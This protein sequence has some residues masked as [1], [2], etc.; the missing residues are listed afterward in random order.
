MSEEQGFRREWPLNSN[1]NTDQ[2]AGLIKKYLHALSLNIPPTTCKEALVENIELSSIY[3]PV[4]AYNVEG[5]PHVLFMTGEYDKD[6]ARLLY[7]ISKY[8]AETMPIAKTV[9]LTVPSPGP[10]VQWISEPTKAAA[11][12]SS[13]YSVGLKHSMEPDAL[14]DSFKSAL[15][16]LFGV[17]LPRMGEGVAMLDEVLAKELM[18]VWDLAEKGR[19]L[20]RPTAR[21]IN[22]I[23]RV[24][25]DEALPTSS[26]F[27]DQPLMNERVRV[28]KKDQLWYRFQSLEYVENMFFKRKAGL[29]EAYQGLFSLNQNPEAKVDRVKLK[30]LTATVDKNNPK[31]SPFNAGGV[32]GSSLKGEFIFARKTLLEQY[33]PVVPDLVWAVA[34]CSVCRT[35][36]KFRK[37]F[38]P[39]SLYRVGQSMER[40]KL[41]L[42]EKTGRATFHC[43][44]CGQ[45]MGF[46]HLILAS[47]AHFIGD[48][49]KDLHFLNE[50]RPGRRRTF[51]Q[52]M[53]GEKVNTQAVS[54]SENAVA[55]V[56]GRSLSPLEKWKDLVKK[57]ST[58]PAYGEIVPG[59]MGLVIPPIDPFKINQAISKFCDNLVQ[60][61]SRGY[62]SVTLEI[63]KAKNIA[64]NGHMI[65][66]SWLDEMAG[67]V[68]GDD[69]YTMAGFVD[70]DVIE[71]QFLD[72]AEK[73][74]LA[75]NRSVDGTMSV[76]GNNLTLQVDLK[77]P[78]VEA[79]Y[80][81]C[82]PA[83]FAV[84]EAGRQSQ[85][86]LSGERT[87]AGIKEYLGK[88]Y[89]VQYN[90]TTYEIMIDGP[91]GLPVGFPF[92]KI[93]NE[94]A[95]DQ[96]AAKRL[97]IGKVG[98]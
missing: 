45:P 70:M 76:C 20:I 72:A 31:K 2:A 79:V 7:V 36:T 92:K 78:V 39:Y 97:I 89:S 51:I 6:D 84:R 21:A 61:Y 80:K 22:H 90:P 33:G 40:I 50:K 27:E 62:W 3:S 56:L 35:R 37:N 5:V 32:G 18:P 69:A 74:G 24:S 75:L 26:P 66:P 91:N 55:K 67:K 63:E 8:K 53:E 95:K 43:S 54:I 82:L 41:V 85:D 68:S 4:G 87:L 58:K 30:V 19:E 15:K 49:G 17:E 48:Q 46:E 73:L 23:L 77:A 59:F 93:I 28:W 64:P 83:M 88:D 10:A 29:S 57:S 13:V 65:F 42:T 96:A 16:K 60:K 34:E 71:K 94:W 98:G 11:L 44:G 81:G 9:F 38:E 12:V 14:A 25:L 1:P 52:T 47:Y 86:L